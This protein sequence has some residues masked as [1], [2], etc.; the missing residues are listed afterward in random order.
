MQ[1]KI[2]IGFTGWTRR[3]TRLGRFPDKKYLGSVSSFELR[4]DDCIRYR[5][6]RC[7]E[8]GVSDDE[9]VETLGIGLMVGGAVTIPH[10]RRTLACWDELNGKTGENGKQADPE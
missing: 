5:P 3:A 8:E 7:R 9:L 1:G 2:S 4:C 6:G 10:L